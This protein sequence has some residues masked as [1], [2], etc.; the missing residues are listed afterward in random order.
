MMMKN[1]I[2][3]AVLAGFW[4]LVSPA[5]SG[6]DLKAYY[7]SQKAELVK[8]FTAPELKSEIT[9]GLANGEEKSGVLR[10]L[11]DNRVRILADGALLT[12]GKHE[13]NEATC[14]QLFAEE[15][16]HAEAIKR[17]RV[18]KRGSATRSQKQIH[19]AS[20]NV[21]STN[22]RTSSN[23]TEN[24]EVE[25]GS[26][27]NETKTRTLVKTLEVSIANQMPHADT[28]TL[29]WYFFAQKLGQDQVVI[30]SQGSEKIKLEGKQLVKRKVMSEA[31][32]TDTITRN[33]EAC[34]GKSTSSQ[35]K[36]GVEEKGY[37]VVLKC[38]NEVVVRKASS[39]L[40]LDPDWFKLNR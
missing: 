8:S 32:A 23:Q 11:S 19:K 28:Y 25:E 39:K 4:M 16:A 31:Y 12:Y 33:W 21:G 3:C 30:H 6:E 1:T 38:G 18:H 17:T 20:L 27:N 22:Q 37:L 15:Y 34:C 13:L 29:K 24:K 10:Q 5:Q 36:S 26:W 9:I 2:L 40:Y 7:E 35:K 14:A